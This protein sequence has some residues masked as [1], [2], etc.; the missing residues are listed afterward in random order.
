MTKRMLLLTSVS[1]FGALGLASAAWAQPAA[2]VETGSAVEVGGVVVTAERREVNVQDVPVAVTAITSAMRDQLG[3]LTIA[4][5]TAFTPGFSYNTQSDRSS[6]RGIS[7]FFNNQA[8]QGSVAI[9]S[10][11]VYTSSTFEL[12][13]APIFF[14]RVE[15]LRGPQGT[16]YG[17]NAIGGAINLISR[18]PSHNWYAEARAS[19]GNF[20]AFE[21]TAAV[22]GPITDWLRFRV[23]GSYDTQDEGYYHNAY[24]ANGGY[25]SEG[26]RRHEYYIE[27]QIDFNI[28]DT[29]DGWIKASYREWD[30]RNGGPGNRAG[31]ALYP[32][33]NGN[34]PAGGV[35]GS[36]VTVSPATGASATGTS[37][38]LIPTLEFGTNE[39]NP[40]CPNYTLSSNIPGVP[41]IVRC[42]GG[43]NR[44]FATNTPGHITL[45]NTPVTAWQFSY[46]GPGFDVR[47]V[48][49]YTRYNYGLDFD[50]DGTANNGSYILPGTSVPCTGAGVPVP[51]CTGAG[52]NS[53]GVRIFNTGTG[54][55]E[56]DKEYNSHEVVIAST[57][58]ADFTW[59]VG[60]YWYHDFNTYTPLTN[61]S[62]AQQP[63]MDQPLASY[64]YC[65]AVGAALRAPILGG[66]AVA[67]P[68][69]N[70]GNLG[71]A[72]NRVNAAPNPTRIYAYNHFT[73]GTE[74]Y[75]GF[76][77]VSWTFT[78]QLTATV[79]LRYSHDETDVQ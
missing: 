49:G 39:V 21:A 47:Y 53:P 23:A 20:G 75:A 55:Y 10:D 68:L 9:Y 48:G 19:Y 40:A 22:S 34:N 54:H 44:S 28:G 42:S 32:F 61:V 8:A 59:I 13:K 17:R 6:I 35:F 66:P 38:P 63:E 76:G 27:A 77:Q 14:D 60:A 45:D 16:L 43:D 2:P 69:C 15:V 46:H 67:Q 56:E 5:V 1:A 51:T 30:N 73:G 79:G 12:G 3:I 37:S 50:L 74:S 72:V 36:G 4:D 11:G 18:R 78:P 25:E 31:P 70:A 62:L 64:D 57:N 26:Q 41:A 58:N 7:R 71:T 24:P 65:V 33:W 29:F 52:T